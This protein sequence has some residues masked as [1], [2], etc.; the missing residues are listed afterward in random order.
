LF[1]ARPNRKLI[2]KV[3]TPIL[4]C[5]GELDFQTPLTETL[6]LIEVLESKGRDYEALL[7]PKLGHSL[8][9]PNDFF[10]EDGGLT[11]LD[12]PT[13]NAM[14]RPTMRKILKRV[15]ALLPE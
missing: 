11:I 9:K 4:F 8:S 10:K 7:F 3:R 5:Q 12:N 2:S 6:D 13:L 14:K 15:K 1:R